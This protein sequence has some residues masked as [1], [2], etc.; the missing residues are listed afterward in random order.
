MKA[1]EFNV[2]FLRD[3]DDNSINAVIISSYLKEE[4]QDIIDNV[5][6]ELEGKWCWEDII[7]ALPQDCMVFSKWDYESIYY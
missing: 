4:I 2:Y 3:I 1:L 5:K 6:R 7:K